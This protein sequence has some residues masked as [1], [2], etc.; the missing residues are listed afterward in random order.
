MKRRQ[1][2]AAASGA[3]AVWAQ[4]PAPSTSPGAKMWNDVYSRAEPI[5][6]PFPNRFL[7]RSLA[8]LRPGRALDVGMGQGRNTLYLAS[9]GWD[10]TGVDISSKGVELALKQAA[11][12]KL[13]IKA[14]VANFREFDLGKAQWDVIT[15]MYIHGLVILRAERIVESLRPGGRLM[16]EGFHQDGK[17]KGFNGSALGFQAKELLAAFVPKLRIIYYEEARDFGDWSLSGEQTQVVRMIARK[18]PA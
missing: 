3:A 8:G 5:V 17:L 11:E 12:R 2:L 16:I 4:A 7:V 14:V 6:N 10:T 9:Q 18:E 1:L 15:E 13:S